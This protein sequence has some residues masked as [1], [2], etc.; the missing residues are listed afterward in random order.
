MREEN[1]SLADILVGDN[2]LAIEGTK[3][4]EKKRAGLFS[5]KLRREHVDGM[6]LGAIS[7]IMGAT[8][9]LGVQTAYPPVVN[10]ASEGIKPWISTPTV[11]A[12]PFQDEVG[13]SA[14]QSLKNIGPA[15][16]VDAAMEAVLT[17]P[18]RLGGK[19]LEAVALSALDARESE[20][21]ATEFL[22][23]LDFPQPEGFAKARPTAPRIPERWKSAYGALVAGMTANQEIGPDAIETFHKETEI[24]DGALAQTRRLL[25]ASGIEE[26]TEKGQELLKTGHQAAIDAYTSS[27]QEPS[28][29]SQELAVALL[30]YHLAGVSPIWTESAPQTSAGK[31]EVPTSKL[32]PTNEGKETSDIVV[33][34]E[35]HTLA[36]PQTYKELIDALDK[37]GFKTL[38]TELSGDALVTGLAINKTMDYARSKGWRIE[39][40]DLPLASCK[41]MNEKEATLTRWAQHGQEKGR[42]PAPILEALRITSEGHTKTRSEF[43]AMN[44]A[45]ENQGKTLHIGGAAHTTEIQEAMAGLN[46]KRP[47]GVEIEYQ[48]VGTSRILET[49]GRNA[50]ASKN[51]VKTTENELPRKI[52]GLVAGP[53]K[54]GPSQKALAGPE[55]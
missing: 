1:P 11:S 6:L 23:S 25:A 51:S 55:I 5:T 37:K 29:E 39:Q 48:T 28:K 27:L 19:D 50:G 32:A 53:K 54:A 20:E 33:I 47:L 26:K 35:N 41:K 3:R 8:L 10:W 15:T 40:N 16:A 22:K 36:N 30:E 4:K 9:L 45:G 21:K 31:M 14:W 34:G 38:S 7:A 46:G 24:A 44:L 2:K 42:S 18:R 17:N 49:W 12:G 52:A 43:I 13:V